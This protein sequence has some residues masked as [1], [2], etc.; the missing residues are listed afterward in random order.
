MV[1]CFLMLQFVTGKKIR[2]LFLHHLRLR[3]YLLLLLRHEML[4][5]QIKILH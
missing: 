4:K 1:V 5:F 2:L 3:S